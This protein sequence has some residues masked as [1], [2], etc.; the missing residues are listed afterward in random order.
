MIKSGINIG[1]R[2]LG[3]EI[4]KKHNCET[5]IARLLPKSSAQL[6]IDIGAN[7]GESIALWRKLFPNAS[8]HGF[9]PVEVNYSRLS[10][11]F[12]QD[13]YVR[14]HK[15][16]MG[17][18]EGSCQINL[19]AGASTHSFRSRG[20][21]PKYGPPRSDLGISEEVAMTTLDKWTNDQRLEKIELCKIDVEGLETDVLHGAKDCLG[22]EK[23]SVVM[24]ELMFVEIYEG[25]GLFY[26]ICRQMSEF[27]YGIYDLPY[28]RRHRDGQMRWGDAIF[29]SDKF[30][31]KNPILA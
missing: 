20:A 5:A 15:S 21:N 1:L 18:S 3:Y 28:I 13:K 4:L 19:S 22:S 27:G 6:V 23:I 12:D 30:R 25:Q 26:D 7:H 2:A 9:E 17:K 24:I 29:I 11:R 16:A 10:E 8:I 14:L 31:S